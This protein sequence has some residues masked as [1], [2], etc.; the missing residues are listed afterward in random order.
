LSYTSRMV[1]YRLMRILNA[2]VTKS[3][4]TVLVASVLVVTFGIMGANILKV[5][6]AISRGIPLSD[7]FLSF[8]FLMPFALSIAIPVGVFVATMLVFGRMS[9]DNEI[10]AMR[11]CG[12]S[13]L[14]IISPLIILAFFLTCVCLVLQLEI[15][16]YY[17]EKGK[18]L[19]KTVVVT[20]PLSMIEPGTSIDY[21]NNSIYIGDRVGKHGIKDIQI[22]QFDKRTKKLRKDVAAAKGQVVVD[23]KKQLLIIELFDASI[24]QHPENGKRPDRTFSEK[25]QLALDYGRK[26]N[27]IKI[28]KKIRLLTLRELF[29]KTVMYRMLGMDTTALD[30]ELNRRIAFGLAPIAFLLLGMPLAIRTSRRETSI[31]L[32]IGVVLA[33][34][35]F[36]AIMVFQ[37]F[38]KYPNIY[39]QYLLWIP[40][41]LYQFGGAVAIWRIARR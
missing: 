17:A 21:E 15:G 12:I 35:Y 29:G 8:L 13:I 32:L 27:E 4:A 33:G 40:N 10:T 11:A 5:F 14:Q 7:A 31:G 19:L 37:A 30:I 3:F 26:F 34:I 18:S 20:R 36:I 23:K 28:G 39:P 9:A 25:F 24:V 41:V 22:F 6:E 2:Y 1:D 38:H 16:P